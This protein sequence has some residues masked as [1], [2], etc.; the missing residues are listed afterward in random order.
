MSDGGRGV[1]VWK[2]SKW[3]WVQWHGNYFSQLVFG[4]LLVNVCTVPAENTERERK[5]ETDSSL[6]FD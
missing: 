4:H 2:D 1:Y 5:G 3:S 6:E